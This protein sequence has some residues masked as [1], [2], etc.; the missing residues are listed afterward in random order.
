[1]P[2]VPTKLPRS[3]LGVTVHNNSLYAIG[4]YD[5]SRR[6]DSV[7]KFSL[8]E[9]GSCIGVTS[10]GGGQWEMS[11]SLNTKRSV[12]SAVVVKDTIIVC[13][14]YNGRVLDI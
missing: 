8:P 13:G 14:G 7:E 9:S 6:L 3:R 5:G 10:S 1:M 12:L 11:A 2:G 4:G